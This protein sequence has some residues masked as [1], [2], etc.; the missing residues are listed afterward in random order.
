MLEENKENALI[1]DAILEYIDLKEKIA[2]SK[3]PEKY[4]KL[5]DSILKK[6]LSNSSV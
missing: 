4:E 6:T 3:T 5:Q 2:G 1:L